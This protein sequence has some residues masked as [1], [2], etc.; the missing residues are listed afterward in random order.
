M[1]YEF[2]FINDCDYD[3]VIDVLMMAT[4]FSCIMFVGTPK[5]L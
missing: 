1:A 5:L 2:V 4:K 3:L